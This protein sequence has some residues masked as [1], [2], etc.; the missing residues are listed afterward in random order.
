MARVNAFLKLLRSG[1]PSNPN[2]KQDNDLL[3]KAHPKSSRGEASLI[4]HELLEVALK[5]ADEYGSP[6]HAIYSMA[7]YTGLGYDVIPALRGAWLRGVRD[8]DVP[9]Q[10]AYD[11]ATNL[12]NSK[13]ADLLPKKRRQVSGE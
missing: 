4:Q 3:P 9:F 13:D 7:E 11:L 10:R 5:S 12:Y 6:E 2:Y 8:G 1:R